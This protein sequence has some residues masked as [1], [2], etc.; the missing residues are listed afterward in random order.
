MITNVL[1]G[2]R[3]MVGGGRGFEDE[4]ACRVGR[5]ADVVGE[6][7]AREACIW[8]SIVYLISKTGLHKCP[9][10]YHAV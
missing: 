7:L 9:K 3:V 8:F 2:S 5:A 10:P 6:G 4:A 1:G